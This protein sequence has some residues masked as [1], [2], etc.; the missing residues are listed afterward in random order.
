M[1]P[2]LEIVGVVTGS[3][4]LD[5]LYCEKLVDERLRS[6]SYRRLRPGEARRVAG[7]MVRAVSSTRDWAVK[8][9]SVVGEAAGVYWAV[10]PDADTIHK[11]AVSGLVRARIRGRLRV[12]ESDYQLLQL[13]ALLLDRQGL[14]AEDAVLAVAVGVD[15]GSLAAALAEALRPP[16]PRPASDP[17]G[18]WRV[19]TRV[20]QRLEAE[21]LAAWLAGYWLGS[22]PPRAR[23]GPARCARCP[24]SGS[25]PFSAAGGAGPGT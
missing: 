8:R 19:T 4:V 9:L 2:P 20:Y 5:Q 23:P 15:S 10:S 11:G 1:R 16:A 25:C 17:E 12:Y 13:A 21:R 3:M 7:L 6:G 22:R 24:F 18:K 14:L